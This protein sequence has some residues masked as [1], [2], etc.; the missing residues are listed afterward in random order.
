MSRL[1]ESLLKNIKEKKTIHSLVIFADAN[2]P[3]NNLLQLGI[4]LISFQKIQY[5]I[6]NKINVIDHNVVNTSL[7]FLPDAIVCSD[8]SQ[9][10][11]AKNLATALKLPMIN[12][13]EEEFNFKPEIAL[14]LAKHQWIND[15]N[16]VS[17]VAIAK[18]LYINNFTLLNNNLYNIILDKI[19]QWKPI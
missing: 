2:K 11:N 9:Y 10:L 18:K 15:I 12:L 6:N 3:V 16:I 13:I 4:K 7:S 17:N 1:I 19:N 5:D 8:L 14:D